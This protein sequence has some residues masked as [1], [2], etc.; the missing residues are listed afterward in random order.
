[1]RVVAWRRIGV[2][3]DLDDAGARGPHSADHVDVG[4][5]GGAM[6]L[7]GLAFSTGE[8]EAEGRSGGQQIKPARKRNKE[9][10][11]GEGE[12]QPT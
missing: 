5:G 8:G 7:Q 2:R 11:R 12:R 6:P 3:A 4:G 9:T 1:M 10:P